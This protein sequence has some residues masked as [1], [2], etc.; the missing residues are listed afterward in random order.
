MVRP[1]V[2]SIIHSLKLVVYLSEQADKTCSISHLHRDALVAVTRLLA[3][4]A[5]KL[6]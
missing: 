2:W 4:R 3:L 5:V 6:T 1:A